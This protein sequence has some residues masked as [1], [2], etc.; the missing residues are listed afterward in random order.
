MRTTY[1]HISLTHGTFQARPAIWGIKLEDN[2]RWYGGRVGT[3]DHTSEFVAIVSSMVYP[4]V[5][6]LVD[7]VTV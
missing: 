7:S 5:D 1:F 2:N 3:A 4:F 6:A